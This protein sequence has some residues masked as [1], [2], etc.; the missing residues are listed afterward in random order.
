[1]GVVVGALRHCAAHFRRRRLLVRLRGGLGGLLL[2]SGR[3]CRTGHT[4]IALLRGWLHINL[5]AHQ[6]CQCFLVEV[7]EHR[8]KDVERFN[9]IDYQRVFLLIGCILHTLAQVV[10]FAQMLFPQFIDCDQ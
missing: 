8:L 1:M 4:H 6:C 5:T 10:E 9:L 7:V 3:G 2:G